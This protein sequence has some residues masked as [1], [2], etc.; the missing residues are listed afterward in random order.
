MIEY[1]DLNGAWGGDEVLMAEASKANLGPFTV[2]PVEVAKR[3]G[4]QNDV[5]RC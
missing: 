1:L 2:F 4:N 3:R 5:C